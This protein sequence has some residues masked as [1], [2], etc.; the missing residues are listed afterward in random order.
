M[1]FRETFA[2]PVWL[3]SLTTIGRSIDQRLA[4]QNRILARLADHVAPAFHVEPLDQAVRS[5]DFSEDP[6]QGRVLDFIDR[7]Q[8]DLGREPTED[9][10]IA[11]LD[12][13]RM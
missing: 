4:E 7:M 11:H 10:I 5:V 3:R 6:V 8:R 1:T 2:L 9:E 13:V 12:G